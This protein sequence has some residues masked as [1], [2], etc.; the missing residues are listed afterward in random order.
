MSASAQPWK[1]EA[2]K[3]RR[4]RMVTS[5][6]NAPVKKDGAGGH[7]W[8][9]PTDVTDFAPVGPGGAKVVVGAPVAAPTV[10]TSMPLQANVGDATQFPGLGGATYVAAPG[11]SQWSAA[12]AAIRAAPVYVSQKAAPIIVQAGTVPAVTLNQDTNRPG[13]SELFDSSHPRNA[14]ARKPRVSATVGTIVASGTAPA[15][16]AAAAEAP[17]VDWTQSGTTGMAGQIIQAAAANPAHLGLYQEAKPGPSLSVLKQMPAQYVLPA[18]HAP[19]QVAYANIP[20]A[21][22]P[23]GRMMQARAR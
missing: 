6:V 2:E 10:V 9:T 18:K 17:A 4:T 14:F 12:P 3:D 16:L 20:Q 5:S 11:A 19:Q 8:G 1:V 13:S 15:V 22:Q 23:K 7:S 21:K